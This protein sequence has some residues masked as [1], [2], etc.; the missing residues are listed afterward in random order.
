[1]LK[2]RILWENYLQFLI[3][4]KRSILEDWEDYEDLS[5]NVNLLNASGINFQEY[6]TSQSEIAGYWIWVK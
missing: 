5:D 1:M 3:Q 4:S 6:Y 2:L